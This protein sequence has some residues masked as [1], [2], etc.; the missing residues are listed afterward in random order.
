MA[1]DLRLVEY[2][3][4]RKI[5]KSASIAEAFHCTCA[6]FSKPL[7]TS[8]TAEIERYRAA[9]DNVHYNPMCIRKNMYCST[10]LSN[11]CQAEEAQ[12]HNLAFAVGTL[13]VDLTSD[14]AN[15]DKSRADKSNYK[16]MRRWQILGRGACLFF[17]LFN[18]SLQ[19][20]RYHCGQILHCQP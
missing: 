5:A 8:D 10:C 2:L 11:H 19:N 20:A 1:R 3:L 9:M 12:Q 14:K 4:L 18:F 13:D 15:E 16:K 7:T 6:G 17:S